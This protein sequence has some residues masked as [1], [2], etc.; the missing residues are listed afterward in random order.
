MANNDIANKLYDMLKIKLGTE[1]HTHTEIVNETRMLAL[2]VFTCTDEEII[3]NV[4]IRYEENH[5][6]VKVTAPDILV[7]NEDDGKW[8]ERKQQLLSH[9]MA[10]GYFDRYKRYLRRQD[11]SEAVIEQ[12]E[13]DCSRILKQCANP[14][15]TL[16]VNERKKKGLV[17]GDVQSGKTANYLGLIN[18]A[19]D[20]GYKIIVLLAGMTDS[21][22][23]QTQARVD[24]GFIGAISDSMSD[25]E[26]AYIGVSD[27]AQL[28]QNYAVPLTNNEND[29]VKFVKKN[30]NATSGDFNKPIILVV[31]KNTSVLDQVVAWLK[32]GSHNINCQNLLIIDDEADNASINTKKPECDPSKI[33]GHIRNLYNNFP[34]ASYVGYTATPF[35]N[36]FVNPEGDETYKD[37]F[38]SDF[39]VLLNAPSNYYGAEKVFSYDGDVHSRALRLLDESE[40]HFLPAKHKRFE[41]HYR[42]LPQSMKEAILCFLISNVIRTKRGA[43]RKHRSM[44]I[45]ISVLNDMHTE[46]HDTVQTYVEKIKNIIEQ[47][48]EK[49]TQDFI[50]NEDMRMLYDIYTGNPEYLKKEYDFYSDIRKEISWEEVKAGLYD[51]IKK[52]ETVIINNQN[53]KNR[54]SYTDSRF[55]NVGARV[56]VIGGYVLSRGLT[57]EGLMVS[58]FSRCSTAYDSLLQMCR[59]FGYR[60]NYEDLCRVYM[61]PAN[62]M[63]FRAVIDAVD[64]LK[65]QFR[66]MIVKKK[67]PDDF[68]LMV[69]ES[70]DTLETSLLITSRNKMYNSGQVVRVLNYGGTYADT[71][72]LYCSTDINAANGG[73]V[74]ALFN[75]CLSAGIEWEDFS[76]PNSTTR[77]KMLRNVPRGIIASHI[78]NLKVPYENTKFDVDNLSAYIKDS[79]AF[80]MWD[81][82]IASGEAQDVK[83]HNQRA[84]ARSFRKNP[85]EKIIRIGDNN[86]RIIDPGI[87]ASGLDGVQYD[88]AKL[89]CEE[90]RE[91]QN[92]PREGAIT[93]PD[94]LSVQTRNPL[95]VIYP[96]QLKLV[97]PE[98]NPTEEERKVI[99]HFGTTEPVF[100]FA[101]GFPAKESA[102]KMTYRA[103]KRKIQ[104]IEASR[105][106]PEVD[107]E[108]YSND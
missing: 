18:F 67:K 90:R 86:N 73:V 51:E 94:Y 98:E 17:V 97:K 55:D 107:E 82:V 49:S 104:E 40:E 28:Q 50:K 88:L 63:N 105:E 85:G 52:F 69:R 65:M 24:S 30:L 4:V 44:M 59:W 11:F 76:I 61:T 81:I 21:L 101:V 78:K 1:S 43:N 36:I 64:D 9:S 35:A 70:P 57:L 5:P 79:K 15:L 26:I 27:D 31:K 60:A 54:F 20:Y 95:L 34:I 47:D 93:V 72:K 10:D 8:F 68:G 53:K 13:S 96:M 14:E 91:R 6:L 62:I 71:S 23:Q 3:E 19:C 74:S 80:P 108:F 25:A 87:F 2:V 92:K 99:G 100:G 106:E 39:I 77:R 29:F 66:E 84:V 89:H 83:Y 22:R 58:Y 41:Y 12:M 103:N 46:I 38:P 75:E 7:A 48:S 45:N 33:N 37:L 102:E 42:E 32:P 56:I 16:N